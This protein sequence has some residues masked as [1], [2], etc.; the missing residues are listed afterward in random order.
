ME[1]RRKS[2]GSRHV[3]KTRRTRVIHV[4]Y[5]WKLGV[6]VVEVDT[7]KRCVKHA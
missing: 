5:M 7:R 2:S 6:K 4:E 1:I 3:E